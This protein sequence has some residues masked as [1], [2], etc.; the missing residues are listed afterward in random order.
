MHSIVSRNRRPAQLGGAPLPGRSSPQVM[1]DARAG[2]AWPG[3]SGARHRWGPLVSPFCGRTLFLLLAACF[4]TTAMAEPSGQR[5]P[6]RQAPSP[7]VAVDIGGERA[8][9]LDCAAQRLEEAARIARIEAGVAQ[10]I[11]VPQAGSPDVRVGVSSL[12]G[13]R[14]R[15]GR[16]LGQSVHPSRPVVTPVNPLGP[17]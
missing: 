17:R 8:G 2:G 11:A 6:A 3:R 13:T 7:C 14:L 15:M 16:N 9:H 10:G 12:S 1:S 4:G 5:I